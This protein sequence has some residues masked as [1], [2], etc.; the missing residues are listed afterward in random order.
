MT[1]DKYDGYL[2]TDSDRCHTY[3]RFRTIYMIQVPDVVHVVH[4]SY[5]IPFTES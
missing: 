1:E 3:D 5:V 2:T 4:V